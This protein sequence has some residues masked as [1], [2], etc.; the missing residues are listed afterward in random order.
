M[1]GNESNAAM[2]AYNLRQ[3]AMG[4]QMNIRGGEFGTNQEQLYN[5]LNWLTGVVNPYP[6]QAA[7]IQLNQALGQGAWPA[8]DLPRADTSSA[9]WGPVAGGGISA[10]GTVGAIKI[11][12]SCL[13]ANTEITM[14]DGSRKQLKKVKVNDE[15][16]GGGTVCF[17]DVGWPQPEREEDYVNV[18]TSRGSLVCTGE[19]LV[20]RNPA[21]NLVSGQMIPMDDG[22]MAR[23][24]SV[25]PCK[26]V[27]S[28]DFALDGAEEYYANGFLVSSMLNRCRAKCLAEEPAAVEA[29]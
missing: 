3:G 21:A 1:T 7:N 17:K 10:A 8:A 15:L 22:K 5:S 25:L 14:K 20:G 16:L 23:V 12:F 13:D 2:Q 26:P 28:G 27:E 9:F 4:N 24:L 18:H 6:S 11:I 29:Q 19:H